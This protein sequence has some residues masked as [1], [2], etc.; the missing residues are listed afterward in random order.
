MVPRGFITSFLSISLLFAVF[1]CGALFCVSLFFNDVNK[2]D[3]AWVEQNFSL[4]CAQLGVRQASFDV[5][6]NIATLALKAPPPDAYW[7]TLSAAGW[8]PL[9]EKGH[10][11][12]TKDDMVMEYRRGEKHL[13]VRL[14]SSFPP[15]ISH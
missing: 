9:H 15:S 11:Y 5:D 6:L 12:A 14:L 3:T 7:E 8:H 1:L 4:P 10:V 13:T 2:V